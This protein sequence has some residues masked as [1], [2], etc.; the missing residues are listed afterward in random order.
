[1][2]RASEEHFS[3]IQLEEPGVCQLV[4][5][6]DDFLN[7]TPRNTSQATSKL[8]RTRL[9]LFICKATVLSSFCSMPSSNFSTVALLRKGLN[10]SLLQVKIS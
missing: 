3:L 8:V 2:K 6:N 10:F 4:E 7:F 5:S 1:M 9:Y